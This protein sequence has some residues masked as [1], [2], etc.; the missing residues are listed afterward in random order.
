MIDPVRKIVLEHRRKKLVKILGGTIVGIG[1]SDDL[2]ECLTITKDGK[3]VFVEVWADD[4]GN[5]PGSLKIR[6]EG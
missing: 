3:A 5:G 4:E 1:V 2:T 6:E